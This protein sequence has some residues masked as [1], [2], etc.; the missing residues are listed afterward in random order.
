MIEI[1]PHPEYAALFDRTEPQRKRHGELAL[2]LR[3][4]YPN[5]GA[6][7]ISHLVDRRMEKEFYEELDRLAGESA[8]LYWVPDFQPTE[9]EHVTL[10]RTALDVIVGQIGELDDAYGLPMLELRGPKADV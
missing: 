5:V 1:E 4:S 7:V 3:A 2:E 10:K 9:D 8:L 6:T